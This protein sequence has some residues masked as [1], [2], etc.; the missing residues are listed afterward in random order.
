MN[1]KKLDMKEREQSPAICEVVDLA[2][3]NGIPIEWCIMPKLSYM[4]FQRPHQ[5]IVHYSKTCL[6][7]H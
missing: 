2:E 3:R 5:V 4:S 6:Q 7:D 1:N